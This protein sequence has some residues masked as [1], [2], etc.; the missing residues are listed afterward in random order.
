MEL[1]EVEVGTLKLPV[2]KNAPSTL[3]DFFA[4][5]DGH[6]DK[7]FLVYQDQR[8][9]F[10]ETR[11]ASVRM[12]VALQAL[13][14]QPGD[15]VAI[16]MRN[17]PEWAI[18]FMAIVAIGAIAV[19]MNSWWTT[20]E[21]EYGLA[22]SGARALIADR[23][24][25]DLVA[26][27]QHLFD[28]RCIVVDGGD[29]SEDQ[30]D[31]HQLM[32]RAGEPQAPSV[33]MSADDDAVLFYTSGSTGFPK[34]V[35]SSHRA[36]IS[37]IWSWITMSLAGSAAGVM[38]LSGEKSVQP[39][40]LLTVPLFHVTGCHSL[41]LLSVVIGRKLVFM[42]KW[43]V[44]DAMAL[45]E[46]EKVTY[47]N[48]VPTMSHE[49]LNAPDRDKY[50][51]SSLKELFA[52]GAA[53]PAEQAQRISDEM[54][55]TPGIGYGL[56]ETNAIGTAN[57]G[58]LYL[59]KPGSVGPAVPAVTRVGIFDESGK[60]MAEGEV[61][62]ICIQGAVNFRCYW[63]KPEATAAAFRDGWFRSGDLGYLDE[64]GY[65]YIVDRIKD[66]IIRGGENISCLEVEAAIYAHSAVAEV[67]VY[68][69]PDE[70]LG[71]IVAATIH[72]KPGRA[73][74]AEAI[75]AFLGQHLAA[76]KIPVV[77]EFSAEQL[78]R[79]GTDKIFKR[80]IREAML[81]DGK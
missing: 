5:C 41:F 45:I 55:R 27:I 9:S 73:L 20:E 19:P 64:D 36:V 76:Y 61:G 77:I 57:A 81:A 2:Y 46:K 65:L 25:M 6:G 13:G 70:R 80:Q 37:A 12:S 29:L 39:C 54:D 62:E 23:R 56:T 18:G 16:A 42:Y 69:L 63:N 14:I 52:G 34:G 44:N 21:L 48:G 40:A 33:P 59:A 8:Y 78:P 51:L 71:E 47:F 31:F 60:A 75:Q 49:L 43:D 32:E 22:D 66:I 4:I 67:A 24:R 1:A 11:A 50:D 28:L 26:P 79:T 74:D 10:A 35:V 53:R 58:K 17:N 38:S 3:A 68:G 72:L 7:P 30:H 15:R